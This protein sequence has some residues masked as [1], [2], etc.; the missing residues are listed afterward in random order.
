MFHM[1]QCT[2]S[3][4]T[5]TNVQ[6]VFKYASGHTP[7][8]A[9]NSEHWYEQGATRSISLRCAA[10]R[11]LSMQVSTEWV[12]QKKNLTEEKAKVVTAV[13]RMYLNAALAIKQQGGFEEKFL[14]DIH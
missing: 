10:L 8:C 11:A 7:M 13:W 4:T 6:Y 14:K 12:A 1:H 2:E 3:L 5:P 9:I